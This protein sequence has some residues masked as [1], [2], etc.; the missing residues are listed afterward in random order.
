[1]TKFLIAPWIAI[2]LFCSPIICATEIHQTEVKRYKHFTYNVQF[3]NTK[4][5]TITRS[6]EQTNQ[7]FHI[8]LTAQLSF[9]FFKF[10][11]Y[12]TYRLEQT[13]VN[14]RS[15]SVWFAP[16]LNM[17]MVKFHYKRKIADITGT[18]ESYTIK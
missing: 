1:M 9:L 15:L 2:V 3:R 10:G 11:E 7:H 13:Q 16:E 18:L 4:V 5:G 12:N 8:R 14:N 6:E 17:Q